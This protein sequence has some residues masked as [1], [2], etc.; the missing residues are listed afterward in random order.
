M[1]KRIT[2]TELEHQ[3]EALIDDT[4]LSGLLHALENVCIYKAS[5]LR[6]AWQDDTTAK[7]WERASQHIG[8]AQHAA[9][10]LGLW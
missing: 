9:F 8:K 3:L 5:H 6:E 7:A 2:V 10:D 4:S 1:E